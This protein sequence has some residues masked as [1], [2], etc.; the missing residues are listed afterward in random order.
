M[1]VNLYNTKNYDMRINERGEIKRGKRKIVKEGKKAI[2]W[3]VILH[4]IH[5]LALVP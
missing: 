5:H 4:G 1:G 2:P 3:L